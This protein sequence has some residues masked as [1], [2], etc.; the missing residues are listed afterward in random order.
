[1]AVKS[2]S[3]DLGFRDWTRLLLPPLLAFASLAAVAQVIFRFEP[4]GSGTSAA[5]LDDVIL[6]EKRRMS[7]SKSSADTVLIGDSSCLMDVSFDEIKRACPGLNCCNLGTLSTLG[8]PR[9]S[10]LLQSFLRAQGLVD[11]IQPAVARGSGSVEPGLRP[12]LVVVLLS[13]E[14]VRTAYQPVTRPVSQIQEQQR[15]RLAAQK[16]RVRATFD[17]SH[18]LRAA[19]T[20]T[21]VSRIR[22][23]VADALLE[24]P[25]P[26]HWGQIYGSL[27]GACRYLVLHAGCAIDPSER[28]ESPIAPPLKSAVLS[29]WFAS[30]CEDFGKV[31]PPG[32]QLAVGLTPIPQSEAGPGYPQLC[33][34]VVME[35]KEALRADAGLTNLP[36][37]LPDHYFATSTHLNEL[38]ARQ[39]SHYLGRA[40]RQAGLAPDPAISLKINH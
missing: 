16:S 13:P 22:A 4:H 5:T 9:F 25:L 15:R 26:G 28:G 35:L 38:G 3:Y 2:H 24:H 10:A 37:T 1:M 12:K 14:M 34:K 19:D 33:R 17:P 27:S 7:R 6:A 20:L 36:P 40:L 23:E 8:L 39:Y 29:P 30:Q 11:G 21:A 18:W 32:I 31:L